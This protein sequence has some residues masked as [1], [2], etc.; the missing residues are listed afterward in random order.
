MFLSRKFYTYGEITLIEFQEQVKHIK[1][2][3]LL[4][5]KIKYLLENEIKHEQVILWGAGK[6]GKGIAK[7][8]L[9]K[10]VPFDWIT[11]NTNKIGKSIYGKLV[12]DLSRLKDE[13]QKVIICAISQ[14]GFEI[15]K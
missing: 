15:P 12:Q 7:Q 1:W 9:E 2:K 4:P 5:L 14:K 11:E 8:L 6:K 3:I 10:K 13:N